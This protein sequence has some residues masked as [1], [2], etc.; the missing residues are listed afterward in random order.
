VDW[1][2]AETDYDKIKLH[3]YKTQLI[4]YKLLLENSNHYKGEVKNLSLEFVEED[5]GEIV[6]L[7]YTP[8]EADIERT[9]KLL[10]IVY[11]K[12]TTLDFP[13]TE[14]YEKNF[15]GILA[16]EEDLLEGNI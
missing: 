7:S 1:D 5:K 16:F 13:D 4:V 9:R 12:I 2:D 8:T 14:K 11:K 3:K 15:K 6:T 10:S